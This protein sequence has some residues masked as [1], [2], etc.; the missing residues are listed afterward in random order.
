MKVNKIKNNLFWPFNRFSKIILFVVFFSALS[1]VILNSIDIQPA[2]ANPEGMVLVEAGKFKFGDEDEDTLEIIDK[3]A[4]YIDIYEVTNDEYKKFKKD[5]KFPSAKAKH[6]V[7]TVSWH[8]AHTYCKALGKRL[9]TEEEWEKAARGTDG[10]AYPWGEDF[11]SG[12]VNSREAAVSDTTPVGKYE[13]GKSFY[14][15]YDMSGNVR[16][17]TDSWFDDDNRIYKVV[18]GGGYIDDEETIYTFTIRKSIPED[19]KAYIGFRCAK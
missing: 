2:M 1:F 8:E 6:P 16:E 12:K 18:K 5:H 9:P 3:K 19:G 4:F 10:K 15:V 13:A 7:T 17:W 11:D 14:G